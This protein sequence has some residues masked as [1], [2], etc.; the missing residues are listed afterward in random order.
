MSPDHHR[1]SHRKRSRPHSDDE[2]G[3][4]SGKR[5]YR[6][7]RD[8][9]TIDRDDTVFRY[10]CPIKKIGSVI[11]RGG[12]IVKQLRMETRAKIKIGEAIPGCDERVITIYSSSDETFGDGGE[13]E[14]LAPAQDALFRIHDRVAADD[15]RSDDS[16]EGEQQVVTAKLLVP[17]DQ[18][19]CILGR[20]GQ[21]V[22]NIRSE[23]GAQIRIIKD[24]I[25]PLCALSSDELIQISGEVLIVKKALHQ[26]ASRL[27]KNPSRTQNLLSSAVSGGYPSGGSL[28][29][30]AGG[31]RIVGIAPLMDPYGGYKTEHAGDFGRPLY[32]ARR[33]EPPAMD[34]YIR[35]VSPVENIASVIGKG[36][37]LINQLRQE[38]RATIKVDSTRTE[39]N[40][41]LITISAR[42]AFDDAYSPTI[43]AAMRL[44]PKCSERIE[45]DSG[46]VSFTTR[47]L[48]PS[49]RIGCILGKGGAII[50]EMRRMTRANIRVLGKE[51]LPK[52]ASEDDEMVQISGEL[53]VAKEALIQITSRL[54]ANVFDR[55]GAVSAIMPVLPYVP[56]A[57]DAGD[58]LDYDR[59]D[60]RR[61]ERGN[62]YP[63]GYGSS[64][65][66]S[67]VYSPY[68]APVGGSSSTPYGVYGGGY[69]SGRSGSSGL[70]SHSST[71]R[72][73][74]YDY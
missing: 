52:V 5:R 18:I 44:Q 60:S 45:R 33:N 58:R 59:R 4:G 55:E 43:E 11:G 53:D 32:Q 73:R 16:S 67:E 12:D 38:T 1:D 31:P 36:G 8:S 34:F 3:G 14:A 41:C 7:D 74:N 54:R 69:A 24:R 56:V 47:I 2:N 6:D 28:M 64:G 61:P 17:S 30:H 46:L 42:E 66:S 39:E 23:T 13:E 35:L 40:D 49:S 26:I 29:S 51:N 72:R 37:A 50:T 68:G 9:H 27:H 71:H 63:G 22:Q 57:P 21:I 25:M 10:L 19:G 62:H 65:L 20:G 15:V 48:V 70:S